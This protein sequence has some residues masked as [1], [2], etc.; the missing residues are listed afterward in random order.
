[1]SGRY[2]SGP[3]FCRKKVELARSAATQD[4]AAGVKFSLRI[5]APDNDRLDALLALLAQTQV[6]GFGLKVS[7]NGWFVRAYARGNGPGRG[8][9]ARPAQG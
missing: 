3:R 2:S 6:D 7:K 9:A 5:P 4:E 8:R 1:M